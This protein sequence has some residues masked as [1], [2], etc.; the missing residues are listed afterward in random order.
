MLQSMRS[1]R[2]GHDLGTE[3][4]QLIVVV[5][6]ILSDFFSE[7]GNNFQTQHKYFQVSVL[8]IM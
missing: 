3:K 2:V 5:T 1:K 8:F 6:E 4:Q 7:L